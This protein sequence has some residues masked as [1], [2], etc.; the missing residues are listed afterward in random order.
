MTFETL[1]AI[2][3]HLCLLYNIYYH[4]IISINLLELSEII[5]RAHMSYILNYLQI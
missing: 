4:M 1:Y 2:Y 3:I 5:N